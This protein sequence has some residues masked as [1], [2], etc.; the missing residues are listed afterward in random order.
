MLVYS[1]NPEA[2]QTFQELARARAQLS[3]LAFAGPGKEGT[4]AYKQQIAELEKQKEQ[5]EAKLSRLS[6][7]YALK[8]KIAKADV[9]KVA[10]A[11]AREHGLSRICQSRDV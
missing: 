6:Q 7:A 9:E 2:V 1:N 11:F 8:Q 3:K 10:K 4:E 5:L